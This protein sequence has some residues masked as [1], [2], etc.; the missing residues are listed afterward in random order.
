MKRSAL[1]KLIGSF[2]DIGEKIKKNLAEKNDGLTQYIVLNFLAEQELW[3][4]PISENDGGL[5]LSWA[6]WASAVQAFISGYATSD[7]FEALINQST[8]LYT[9][10]Q[11]GSL[12]QK[13]CVLPY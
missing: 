8:V 7:L 1:E 9:L 11:F 2:F 5:G 6:D 10:L 4:I 3:K 12:E 13:K